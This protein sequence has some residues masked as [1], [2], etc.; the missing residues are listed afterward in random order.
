MRACSS[1]EYWKYLKGQ[2]NGECHRN[3]PRPN[4]DTAVTEWPE[5]TPHDWCGDYEGKIEPKELEIGS[6]AP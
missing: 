5:T 1:C 4:A 3:S 6:L 2:P